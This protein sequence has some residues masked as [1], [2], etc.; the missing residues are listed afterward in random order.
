MLLITI[1][2]V[3]FAK[4]LHGPPMN[5]W[6]I[7][8]VLYAAVAYLFVFLPV[9]VLVLFSFNEGA[10]PIPPFHRSDA[11]LVP[12]ASRRPS[13]SRR[14]MELGDGR[15]V[16]SGRRD[17]PWLL[18][19]LCLSAWE[20][21]PTRADPRNAD[22]SSRGVLPDHRARHVNR[23]QRHRPTEITVRSRLGAFGHQ[24]P[25]RL[26]DLPHAARRPSG[27]ESS[28]PRGISGRRNG[29]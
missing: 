4:R 24:P 20:L 13:A 6:R 29:R 15:A 27:R 14:S 26:R 11:P 7:L 19:C 12:A 17:R 23:R 3:A 22:G 8:S 9:V 2:Y 18:G 25:C 10:L 16:L 1:V 21:A 28:A 5:V